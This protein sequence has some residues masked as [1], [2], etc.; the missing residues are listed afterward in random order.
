MKGVSTDR[1]IV[2]IV[3]GI[4][5]G[6]AI[7]LGFILA[8][9]TASKLGKVERDILP[10]ANSSFGGESHSNTLGDGYDYVGGSDYNYAD[11][12]QEAK[13]N[14]RPSQFGNDFDFTTGK[15]RGGNQWGSSPL[16][17]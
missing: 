17:Q 15:A 1:V 6:F 16:G 3:G 11:G 5:T 8:Q 7:G 10:P 12:S 14:M 13:N 9:K 4:V 2:G